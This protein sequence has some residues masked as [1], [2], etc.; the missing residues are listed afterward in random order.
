MC[1]FSLGI[2]AGLFRSCSFLESPGMRKDNLFVPLGEFDHNKIQRF[3]SS[4][5]GAVFLGKMPVRSKSF[6]AVW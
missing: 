2:F 3:I 4:G 6:N 5:I 1:L